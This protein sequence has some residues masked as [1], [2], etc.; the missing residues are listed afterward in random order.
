MEN[1]KQKEM[2]SKE[3]LC[4]VCEVRL[5]SSSLL[6]LA[7]CF[8]YLHPPLYLLPNNLKTK[9]LTLQFLSNNDSD[10]KKM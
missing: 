7:S 10:L 5:S 8:Y 9:L 6:V 3:K 4:L 1:N 2:L